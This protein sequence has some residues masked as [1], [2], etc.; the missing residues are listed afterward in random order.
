MKNRSLFG[1]VFGS[2][3]VRAALL[4]V[5]GIASLISTYFV[6]RELGPEG[7]AVFAILVALPALLPIS[8]FGL[9]VALTDAAAGKG[10]R[11]RHF[12]ATWTKTFKALLVIAAAAIIAGVLI[13]LLG[14]WHVLLAIPAG[15][16]SELAGFAIVASLAISV[17]LATGQRVLLGL[18]QQTLATAVTSAAPALSLGLV[19]LTLT[20]GDISYASLAIAYS[21]GPVIAQALLFLIAYSVLRRSSPKSEDRPLAG[22]ERLGIIRA[23]W[24]MA[25]L[26]IVLPLAYQSDRIILSHFGS[27]AEVGQYALVATLYMPLLSVI[28]VGSLALWPLFMRIGAAGAAVAKPYQRGT[29]IFTA[30]GLVLGLG[31]VLAGPWVSTVVYQGN[32]IASLDVYMYFALML[33]AFGYNSA[34]GMYLMDYS[35]RIFQAGGAVL[36]VLTKVPLSILLLSVMGVS[37]VIVGTLVPMVVFMVV[38]SRILANVRIRRSESAGRERKVRG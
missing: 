18:G 28:T 2:A 15:L 19:V 27:L 26:G 6:V 11:S 32:R 37:G 13:A 31:L 12:R 4:P 25:L 36:L 35:G 16:D 38:P 30:L 7:F 24:P 14:W 23:A 8:D 20:F 5:S 29:H 33:V 17:P 1:D 10:I 9:G 34:A 3:G 21:L 22:S